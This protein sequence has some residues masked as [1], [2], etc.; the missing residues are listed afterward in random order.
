MHG[1]VAAFA[2]VTGTSATIRLKSGSFAGNMPRIRAVM[3]S[4]TATLYDQQDI[5][6]ILIFRSTCMQGAPDKT[7]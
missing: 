7:G 5:F 1:V 4:V 3:N 2:I 6:C